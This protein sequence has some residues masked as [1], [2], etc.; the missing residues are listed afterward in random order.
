VAKNI[1]SRVGG[2]SPPNNYDGKVTCFCDAGFHKGIM[3]T[4]DYENPPVP[5]PLNRRHWLGKVLLNKL[6]WMLI[7]KARV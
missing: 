2:Q 1:A 3:M 6:Y 4:F 7:P 5:P